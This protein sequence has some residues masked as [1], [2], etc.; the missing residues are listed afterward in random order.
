MALVTGRRLTGEVRGGN[1]AESRPKR[2]DNLLEEDQ[3]DGLDLRPTPL[4]DHGPTFH[5]NEPGAFIWRRIDGRR[6]V[7][8]VSAQLGDAYGLPA[9]AAQADTLAFLAS[10]V[11][12]GLVFYPAA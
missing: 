7:H 10:L 6:S 5:L 4:D 1:A 11:R 2:A 9:P 8:A 12:M 3:G